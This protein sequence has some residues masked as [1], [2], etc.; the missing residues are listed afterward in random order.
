M[1]VQEWRNWQTRRLQ[2]PVVAISCGFKSRFLHYF[3]FSYGLVF[4]SESL[5][6]DLFPFLIFSLPL[7]FC[8]LPA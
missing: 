4:V 6:S 7:F 5:F 8:F 1:N 3:L 2:V